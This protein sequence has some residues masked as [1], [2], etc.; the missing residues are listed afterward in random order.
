MVFIDLTKA[1]GS[2]DRAEL[3]QILLKIRC[4]Q[5]FVNIIRSFHEGMM[6]QVTDDG[7]ISTAFS[8]TNGT[9]Q[10]CALA[11]LLFC[12]FFAMMLLIAFK[13]CKLGIPVRFRTDGNV[14]NLRRL[15]ARRKTFSAVIRDLLYADYCALLAH[16]EADA[17]HLFDRFYTAA[18][19]FGLTV[20]LKKTEVL[21]QSRNRSSYF[22][23]SLTAGDIELPVVDK[24]CYPAAF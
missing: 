3:W 4:P 2:V 11:P 16:S 22:S 24:F 5:K 21:L 9:K 18:S 17:Q 1:F 12:I 19:R 23:P 13:D 14:F 6:C 20:S 8:T 7:E 10:G 15:Q